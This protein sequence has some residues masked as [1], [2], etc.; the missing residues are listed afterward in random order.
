P[1]AGLDG[2]AFTGL[3]ANSATAARNLLTDLTASINSQVEDFGPVSAKNPK[4]VGYPAIKNNR[5]W[6]YQGEMSAYFKDDWKFRPDLTLNL[7]VHWEYYGQPYEH[8]GLAAR[9][10]GDENSFL[11]MSCTSSPGTANF[12]STCTNLT[13]V[14]FVGKNS[15]HPDISTNLKGNDLNN[16]APS[17][18]LSWNIP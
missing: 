17:T 18:G 14:Q 4:L 3:S 11:N 1:V 5:H 16:W 6:N 13:Q 10:I 8:N 2:T 15:T 9:V 7:G 12:T